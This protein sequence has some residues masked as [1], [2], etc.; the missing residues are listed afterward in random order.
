MPETDP[1]LV[2]MQF[3]DKINRH[4]VAAITSMMAPEIRFVDSLGHEVRGVNRF[5]AGWDAYFALFPDY[6]ITIRQCF[7]AGQVVALFGR[8]RGTLAENG[9]LPRRNRWAMPAAWRA[10]IRKD[11]LV[12]W[13]VYADNTPVARLLSHRDG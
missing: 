10:V 2:A 8:A 5:R 4:D 3:V 13:Q 12:H 6:Q 1:E 11:R 7:S 9:E